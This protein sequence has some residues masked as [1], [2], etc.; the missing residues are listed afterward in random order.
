MGGK[1]LTKEEREQIVEM[2][3]SGMTIAKIAEQLKRSPLTVRSILDKVDFTP[4]RKPVECVTVAENPIG[5][6][7][8]NF[9]P[10]YKRIKYLNDQKK[11]ID[12]ELRNLRATLQNGIDIIDSGD[13]AQPI[14]P[15]WGVLNHDCCTD[16]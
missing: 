1:R 15:T 13:T 2:R 3:N 6:I 4:V 10:L 9:T 14:K 8:D 11:K 7:I 5:N 16:D 12:E